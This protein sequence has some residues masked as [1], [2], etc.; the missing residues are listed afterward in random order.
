[1][2][3][4]LKDELREVGLLPL[5]LDEKAQEE[6]RKSY[7][8]LGLEFDLSKIET[9]FTPG[10][11]KDILQKQEAILASVD[12]LHEMEVIGQTSSADYTG[13]VKH[14][15][16]DLEYIRAQGLHIGFKLATGGVPLTSVV[17]VNRDPYTP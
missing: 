6:Y 4:R 7:E 1:M 14:I 9:H 11:P 13:L 8:K 15:K 17:G 2:D 12:R 3:E 16:D 10:T 5:S